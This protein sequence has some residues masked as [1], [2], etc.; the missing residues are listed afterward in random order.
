M[1][2]SDGREVNEVL[3]A[4]YG[5]L[6]RGFSNHHVMGAASYLGEDRLAQILLYD[7]GPFPGAVLA[8]SEGIVVE[9]FRVNASQLARIDELEEYRADDPPMGLYTRVQLPTRYGLAWVYLYQGALAGCMCQR[10]GAWQEAV[11]VGAG[12]GV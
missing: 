12:G 4:V 11:S 10:E 9:V 8:V 5:T 3:V 2:T 6:K 1:N 7:L